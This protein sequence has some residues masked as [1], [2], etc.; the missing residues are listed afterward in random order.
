MEKRLDRFLVFYK[1]LDRHHYIKQWV[2]CGGHSDHS[3]IFLEFRDEPIKPPSSL[4]LNKTW[5][6][7]SSFQ[8]LI[9][10]LWVPFD[11]KSRISTAFQFVA[12]IN[13][14]KEDVKTQ[15]NSKRR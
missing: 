10:S 11:P 15:T 4:K 3:P 9:S 7:D 8:P 5:L 14:I 6:K 2:G 12:N 13:K 1:V